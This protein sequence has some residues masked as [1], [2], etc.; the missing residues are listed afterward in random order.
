M[1]LVHVH[2]YQL[3]RTILLVVG[4]VRVVDRAVEDCSRS[5]KSSGTGLS[6]MQTMHCHV[7]EQHR[8][9]H[10]MAQT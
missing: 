6:S 7:L 8:C 10:D 5:V 2:S 3:S 9:R 1:P 4:D